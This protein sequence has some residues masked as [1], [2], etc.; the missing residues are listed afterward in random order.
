M[1]CL[2]SSPSHDFLPAFFCVH[3]T[4]NPSRKCYHR[5]L[6]LQRDVTSP[7]FLSHVV[8]HFT[9]HLVQSQLVLC[10][11]KLWY[12]HAGQ[13]TPVL[14]IPSQWLFCPA[15]VASLILISSQW[16]WPHSSC[17][18]LFKSPMG[19]NAW[20]KSVSQHIFILAVL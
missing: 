13:V 19:T 16:K 18:S 1:G 15:S 12:I 11:E 4:L 3:D 8:H 20:Y 14:S 7:P 6:S 9:Q 5:P 17:L 10:L 2:G